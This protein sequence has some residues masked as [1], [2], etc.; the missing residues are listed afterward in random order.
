M[1]EKTKGQ[2][3]RSYFRGRVLAEHS[4]VKRKRR[5]KKRYKE[6][7]E[8]ELHTVTEDIGWEILKHI[9]QRPMEQKGDVQ[10]CLVLFN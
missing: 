8:E 9:L 10:L 6:V 4:Q 3:L 7:G 1:F 5:G 2:G